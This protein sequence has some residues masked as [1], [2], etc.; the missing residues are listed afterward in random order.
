M[1]WFMVAA[2]AIA[3]W[4]VLTGFATERAGRVPQATG[5]AGPGKSA[6][7]TEPR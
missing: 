4:V 7:P 2:M 1:D 6:A 3:G 5:P